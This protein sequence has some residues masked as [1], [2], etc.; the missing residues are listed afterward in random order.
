MQPITPPNP[1]TNK[2]VRLIPK[3]AIYAEVFG[4]EGSLLLA[5]KPSTVEVFNDIDETLVDFFRVLRDKDDFHEFVNL[6]KN[7][8]HTGVP[9]PQVIKVFEWF[10]S[11]CQSFVY[12]KSWGYTAGEHLSKIDE[13][14]ALITKRLR[15]VSIDS[16][17]WEDAI[18]RYD[19][20][21]TLLYLNPP[22]Q[23]GSASKHEM[24]KRDHKRLINTLLLDVQGKV[25][26]SGYNNEVYE[27]LEDAQWFTDQV[28]VDSKTIRIW[29]NYPPV[30][31]KHT[32][33]TKL[34]ISRKLT[35]RTLSKAHRL[36]ISKSRRK[37]VA[38]KGKA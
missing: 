35:G 15:L 30:G 11:A 6:I 21:S 8:K 5:K 27:P 28:E 38:Q 13:S 7:E 1:L 26:I 12:K 17:A 16:V 34:K 25:M 14:L 23:H 19:S 22:P 4:G 29:M 10:R 2:L 3:H 32:R 24:T 33:E 31:R 9:P 36:N 37:T 18:K 20:E